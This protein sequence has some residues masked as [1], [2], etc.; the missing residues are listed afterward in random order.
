MESHNDLG[1]GER[2]H[3]Y[4]RNVYTKIRDD[5]PQLEK[6]DVLQLVI[7]D[8]NDTAGPAGLVPTLLVFGVLPRLPIYPKDLPE[9]R[10]RMRAMQ[11]ARSDMSQIM[12][13]ARVHVA[14]NRNVPYAAD[15]KIRIRDKVLVYRE[16][17]ISKWTGPYNF[18]DVKGKAIY[19]DVKGELTQ[20][21]VD[22]VKPFREVDDLGEGD[23]HE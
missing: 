4:L 3:A 23:Q 9:Q 15:T 18:L 19:A 7:K 21:S 1:N 22:K 8:V 6:A 10:S 2:Y 17:P 16:N 13:K 5:V 14:L 11:L 20:F 12:A